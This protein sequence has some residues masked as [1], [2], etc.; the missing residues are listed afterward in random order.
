[1][2]IISRCIAGALNG[3]SPV[4]RSVILLP[5]PHGYKLTKATRIQVVGEITDH[6]NQSLALALLPTCWSVASILAPMFGGFL[7]R[8]ADHFPSIFGNWQLFIDYPYLLP[9]LCGAS[10][11]TIGLILGAL[12]LE[13]VS[14]FSFGFTLVAHCRPTDS[15]EQSKNQVFLASF[16]HSSQLWS[17]SYRR[18]PLN[19]QTCRCTQSFRIRTHR[20]QNCKKRFD[21]MG[22]C[23]FCY[24]FYRR[25]MESLDVHSCVCRRPEFHCECALLWQCRV[26]TIVADG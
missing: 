22:V 6:T 19:N 5:L 17:H 25:G 12:F 23:C 2:M 11:S 3:N 1:M 7:A 21:I 9:C 15:R 8:P 10:I 13:E 18:R 24:H 16:R 20:P 4:L 26:L 14:T